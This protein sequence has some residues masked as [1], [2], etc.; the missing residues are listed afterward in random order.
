MSSAGLVSISP[1]R[2]EMMF[3][4]PRETN[5]QES[6]M[7]YI[8]MSGSMVPLRV[9][10]SDSIESVKL[11]IHN[12]KGIFTRNQKLVCGGRE[13]AKS[14]SLVRD[15]GVSN[16][17]VLHLVLRL[18][19]LQVINVNTCCG[20]EFTFHVERNRNVGY[21]KR[22]VAKNN[23]TGGIREDHEV[24]LN[25]E[26]VEDHRLITDISK[27]NNDAVI[28]LFVRKSAKIRAS[29]VGKNFELSITAPRVN[30]VRKCDVEKGNEYG[31]D[32]DDLRVPRNVPVRDTLLEPV[33]VNPKI[34]LPPEISEMLRSTLEGLESGKYPI[35]SSEVLEERISCRMR[36]GL[37]IY[38]FSNQLTRNQWL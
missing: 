37:S 25:G 23:R 7:I 27:D 12:C 36:Q 29:P 34:V 18:S 35:R 28:H 30:V 6:I 10:E 11:R 20:K 21:V 38:P 13:L 14:N 17:N 15:Y 24:L 32:S 4:P 8:A 16:G 33:I 31:G 26:P 3:S 19:D 5:T 1:F 22:K 2:E 9:M